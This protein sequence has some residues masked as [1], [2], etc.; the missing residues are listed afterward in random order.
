MSSDPQV[1]KA[2]DLHCELV[3]T[4]KGSPE[5]IVYTEEEAT[6]VK[7]KLDLWIMPVL[8]ISYALQ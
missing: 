8:M 7:R 2:Q 5:E 1:E 4:S 3:D 6:R